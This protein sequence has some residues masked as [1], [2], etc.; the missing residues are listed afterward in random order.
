MTAG[1]KRFWPFGGGLAV[2]A[3]LALAVGAPPALAACTDPPSPGVNWQ[4]CNFD[5]LDLREVDLHGARL[6]DGSFFRA[7]LSR[8]DLSGINGFRA[9]FVN[10]AMREAKLYKAKL[11]GADF[12]KAD[13]TAASLADAD[14]RQARFFDAVLRNADLTGARLKGADFTR[15]DLSGATWADGKRICAEGSVGRCN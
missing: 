5:G 6:R 9:K 14:L 11:S 12:T 2:A 7:D 8:S 4:R 3:L 13:L 15:A 10:A 1:R